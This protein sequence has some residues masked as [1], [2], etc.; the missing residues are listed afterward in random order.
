MTED[1]FDRLD[2][3]LDI[4]LGKLDDMGQRVATVERTQSIYCSIVNWSGGTFILV[5]IGIMGFLLKVTLFH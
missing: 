5:C 3:K 1:H 4:V 2:R